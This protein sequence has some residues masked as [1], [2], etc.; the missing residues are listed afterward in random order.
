SDIQGS[1]YIPEPTLF[2][3]HI[4][5]HT[6][7]HY[8]EKGAGLRNLCDIALYIDKNRDDIDFDRVEQL[9]GKQNFYNIYMYILSAIEKYYGVKTGRVSDEK[10]DTEKFIEYTLSNGVFGKMDNVLVHQMAKPEDDEI[11]GK[12]KLFFPSAKTLDYR[13]TYLKK[14]PVLLPFAWVHRFF[15]AIFCRGFSVFS[16]VRDMKEAEKFSDERLKQLDELGIKEK[17]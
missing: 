3:A 10:Y 2:L 6:G 13:Y 7:K 12:R 4:M 8:I 15:S 11:S 14:Y 1:V 9:C 17:H 5:I 16:M